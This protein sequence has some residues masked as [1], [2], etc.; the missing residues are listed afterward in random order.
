[1]EIKRTVPRF[2]SLAGTMLL[3]AVVVVSPDGVIAEQAS[4]LPEGDIDKGKEFFIQYGCYG[5]HGIEGQGGFAGPK[6]GPEPIPFRA[7][8]RYIRAP[9]GTMPPY[10]EKLLPDQEDLADIYEYLKSRPGPAPLSVL[11]PS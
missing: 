3:L 2:V 6:L 5:C 4:T 7:F 8:V 10:T 1:M 9:R 11:P